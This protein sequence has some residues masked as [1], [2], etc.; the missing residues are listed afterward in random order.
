MGFAEPNSRWASFRL[1]IA[2]LMNARHS[3][4][5]YGLKSSG[6]L[7]PYQGLRLILLAGFAGEPRLVQRRKDI[8]GFEIPGHFK[9]LRAF[10]RRVPFYAVHFG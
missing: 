4:V 8:F 2:A 3:D 6:S 10:G 9:R 5:S 7:R 1:G